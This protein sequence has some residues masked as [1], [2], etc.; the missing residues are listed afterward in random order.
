MAD[1][2]I[3]FVFDTSSRMLVGVSGGA[4]ATF[5]LLFSFIACRQSNEVIIARRSVSQVGSTAKTLRVP[6]PFLRLR[7][8]RCIFWVRLSI[9]PLFVCHA[10]QLNLDLK[11]YFNP[12]LL[13]CKRNE[14]CFV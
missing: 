5:I 6:D 12:I 11:Y 10:I 8:R 7:Y 13:P 2:G 9:V 3:G 4:L 1:Q 14:Q